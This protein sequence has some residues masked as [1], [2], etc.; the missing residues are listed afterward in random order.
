MGRQMK[1]WSSKMTLG[2]L[3]GTKGHFGIETVEE[4]CSF[5]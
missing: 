1:M 2:V 5:V 3:E 4:Q